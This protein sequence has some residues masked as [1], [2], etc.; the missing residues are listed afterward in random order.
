MGR[1]RRTS[2]ARD[3]LCAQP[4]RRRRPRSHLAL[5][6]RGVPREGGR[7]EVWCWEGGDGG[8]EGAQPC[9]GGMRPTGGEGRERERARAAR[10]PEQGGYK[11]IKERAR[12]RERDVRVLER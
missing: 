6:A 9:W 1:R 8:E 4:H 2:S 7:G 10:G 11:A 3:G 12:E 5:P